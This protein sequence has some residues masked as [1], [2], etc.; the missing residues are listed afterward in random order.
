MYLYHLAVEDNKLKVREDLVANNSNLLD[1]NKVK[2]K[3]E[4]AEFFE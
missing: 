1:K 4:F 3:E 2:I